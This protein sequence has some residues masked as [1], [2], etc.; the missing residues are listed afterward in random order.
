MSVD[1]VV[2]LIC[3]L[4][5]EIHLAGSF[6]RTIIFF[7]VRG[8]QGKTSSVYFAPTALHRR[9]NTEVDE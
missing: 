3:L 2:S 9:C 4:K 7:A 6:G 5:R 8:L 1:S